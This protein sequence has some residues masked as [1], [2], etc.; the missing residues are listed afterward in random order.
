[1]SSTTPKKKLTRI[2]QLVDATVGS[3]GDP[4]VDLLGRNLRLRERHLVH[5]GV[6]VL[7]RDDLILGDDVD[8][9]IHEELGADLEVVQRVGFLN[10][11]KQ[12]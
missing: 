12:C 9:L 6:V 5:R 2:D 10:T 4:V 1:M 3:F 11:S 7:V 8:E